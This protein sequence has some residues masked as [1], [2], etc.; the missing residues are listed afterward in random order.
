MRERI[1]LLGGDLALSTGAQ[2]TTI[3]ASLPRHQAD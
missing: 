2:G 3:A 1:T